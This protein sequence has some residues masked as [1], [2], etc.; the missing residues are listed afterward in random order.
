MTTLDDI[1]AKLPKLSDKD[2]EEVL[3]RARALQ[4]LS[5][6]SKK[7]KEAKA[8]KLKYDW[9]IDGYRAALSRRG[10]GVAFSVETI[11]GW[12]AY[13][14]YLQTA[15]AV[16][17][18]IDARIDGMD[19]TSWLA[20]GEIIAEALCAELALWKEPPALSLQTFLLFTQ[21]VPQAIERSYP[22]YA[23]QGWLKLLVRQRAARVCLEEEG[24][25]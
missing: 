24:E 14:S 15:P 23:R 4:S 2:L 12:R 7:K 6:P 21:Y 5:S 9:L 17:E 11:V 13:K 19:R 16:V 10:L 22:G 3:N 25:R 8:A 20:L 1:L 18:W